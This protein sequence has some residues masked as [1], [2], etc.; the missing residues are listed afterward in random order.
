MRTRLRATVRRVLPPTRQE[1]CYSSITA[2]DSLGTGCYLTV[3]VVLFVQVIG[4]SATQFGAALAIGGVL[5]LGARVLLSRL[6]DRIGHRRSLVL[7]HL[8]RAAAFPLYLMVR[9]YPA[10]LMLTIVIVV[11]DGWE[12]PIRKVVLY[13]FARPDDRIRIAAYNRS[14]YNLMFA[15]GSLLGGIALAGQHRLALQLV[16]AGNA[17]S[18]LAAAALS[19]RL[20]PDPPRSVPTPGVG[21]GRARFAAVGLLLGTLF[22]CTAVLTIGIPLLVLSHFA[23][24]PSLIGLAL[25]L[26]MAV[27][28]TLQLRASRGADHVRGALR[29]ATRGGVLL[30]L[31][32]VLFFLAARTGGHLALGIGLVL[33]GTLVLSIGELNASAAVWGLGLQLRRHDLTA[34]NQALWSMYNS[35]PQLVG[36]LV[37]AWSLHAFSDTGW[38]VL[39]AVIAAAA[40]GLTPAVRGVERRVSTPALVENPAT[41]P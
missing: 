39:A 24:R 18:F 4:I 10:F 22:L 23:G 33:L 6:S 2:V 38:L 21:P 29:V 35:L 32:C 3:G 37:V 26:N 9:G 16:V 20:P 5:S 12:S 34:H 14:V 28:V 25:T 17:L 30:S 7:V 8:L 40:G 41:M 36:P 1:R 31:A 11:V 13:A 19:C 27:S 15:A